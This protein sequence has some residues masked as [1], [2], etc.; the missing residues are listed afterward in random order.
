MRSH[1][2]HHSLIA[3]HVKIGSCALLRRLRQNIISKDNIIWISEFEVL[4]FLQTCNSA[5]STKMLLRQCAVVLFQ[6]DAPIA[7]LEPRQGHKNDFTQ[8]Q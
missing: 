1:T 7:T 6:M 3:I 8:T 2:K 4:L 5:L